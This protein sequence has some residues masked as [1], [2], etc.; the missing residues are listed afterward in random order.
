MWFDNWSAIG[1]LCNIITY[2]DLYDARLNASVSVRDLVLNNRWN[3]PENWNEMSPQITSMA[4]PQ[5]DDNAFDK[6][7]WKSIDGRTYGVFYQ[8]SYYDMSRSMLKWMEESYL[9]EE[10]HNHLFFDY[11]FSQNIWNDICKMIK[12]NNS[13]KDWE[14][15][16]DDFATKPNA[17]SIWSV[18]RRLS[19]A[20][21]VYLI[22][23]ERNHRIFKDELRTSAMVFNSIVDTIRLKLKSLKVKDTVAVKDVERMAD[24]LD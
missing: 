20:A 5:V 24:I 11:D 10:S 23:K 19:I 6:I 3:W 2:R 17:N 21:T 18:V 14:C 7:M 16:I 1:P 12:M 8:T 13:H 4:N 15:T 22:W 9:D